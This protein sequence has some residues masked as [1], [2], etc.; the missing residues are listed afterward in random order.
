MPSEMEIAH[1][2]GKRNTMPPELI[3]VLNK[4]VADHGVIAVWTIAGVLAIRAVYRDIIRSGLKAA[5]DDRREYYQARTA[6]FEAAAHRLAHDAAHQRGDRHD[7]RSD[8]SME[9]SAIGRGSPEVDDSHGERSSGRQ[10]D[11]K[12]R[13][14]KFNSAGGSVRSTGSRRKQ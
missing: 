12:R 14:G 8:D 6:A 9:C 4:F 7:C 10:D 3:V 13:S 11:E 2:C 1:D 5:L